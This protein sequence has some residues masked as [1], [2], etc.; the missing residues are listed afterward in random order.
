MEHD[1][2]E[3]EEFSR[4]T[5]SDHDRRDDPD[6][7]E[8]TASSI[9]IHDIPPGRSEKETVI[10]QG[11]DKR[12][13]SEPDFQS[14]IHKIHDHRLGS[15]SSRWT[16]Q[17]GL[18][19]LPSINAP[20]HNP[21]SSEQQRSGKSDRV[22][23]SNG[24][25]L[26]S[27]DSI[28]SLCIIDR[29]GFG[30][31]LLVHVGIKGVESPCV[32]KK[33]IHVGSLD[34]VRK[35]RKEFKIQ[36]KLYKCCKNRIPYPIFILDLLNKEYK[37]NFGFVME[38]C[39][40]GNVKE[41]A[42]SWCRLKDISSS[43]GLQR[44]GIGEK[45]EEKD[46]EGSSGEYSEDSMSD[47]DSFSHHFDPMTLDPLKVSALCVEIIECLDDVFKANPW[48]IHRDIKPENFLIKVDSKNNECSVVL[49]DH[50]LAQIKRSV[51]ESSQSSLEN[52]SSDSSSSSTSQKSSKSSTGHILC[53]TYAY[54]SFEALQGMHSQKS[55]AYSLGITI[56]ALFQCC[57]P[58][59]NMRYLLNAISSTEFVG[60]L[61]ELLSKGI[62]PKLSS[63]PL[64]ASILSINSKEFE[65]V[66]SCLNEVFEGLT[67]LEVG[68]RMSVHEACEKVQSIKPLLPKIGE[69]WECPSIEDIVEAHL[70]KHK[71]NSGCIVEA[72]S[73]ESGF[74]GQSSSQGQ[75][76][77]PYQIPKEHGKFTS[78]ATFKSEEDL[79]KKDKKKDEN[80]PQSPQIMKPY[81]IPDFQALVRDIQLTSSQASVRS[82]FK[83]SSPRLMNNFEDWNQKQFFSN[84]IGD[85]SSS[86]AS[87]R[88]LFTLCFEC[89]SLFVQHECASSSSGF[90]DDDSD[91]SILTL[92]ESSLMELIGTFLTPMIRVEAELS[93]MDTA[94][95][96]GEKCVMSAITKSLVRIVSIAEQKVKSFQTKLSPQISSV[97]LRI[98]KSLD[99][100]VDEIK[101]CPD[102]ESKFKLYH[103]HRDDILSVFFAFQSKREIEKHKREIVLCVHCLSWFVRHV[104]SGNN[105]FLPIPDL[106][107]LI[108]TFIGHL[109]R[110]EE[111]LEGD[112][113]EEY[114]RIC[115]S[116][117]FKVK[118]ERDHFLPKISP[119]LQSILER[120]SKE[121]LG[122][123]ISRYLLTT[124]RNISISP[125]SSIKSSIITLINPYIR[126]WLRIY[127]DS[128]CYGRWMYILSKITLSSD[129]ESPNKSLCSEAWP[130]FR[131]VLDVVKREFVGDKI[132]GDRYEYVL[133]F[134][135]NLCC[136]PSHA[137]E[138]YDNVKDL[139]DGWLVVI[140]KKEH[141]SGIN[142]WSR[143]ISMFST[144][145]HLVPR[146]SPK[147]D[148]DIDWCKN[149]G[150]RRG[151]YI[152][153]LENCNLIFRLDK[154]VKA[155]KRCTDI[156]SL[157]KLF[158][159]R[160]NEI[161]SVFLAYQS[162]SKIRR[163]K[164]EIVLCVHCLSWFVCHVISGNNIFL[165]IPDLND[166]IDTFIGHLSRCE[167]VLE[168]D[169]DEEYCRICV[170]YTHKV[171]DKRDHFL[172]KISPTLQSILERGSKEKLGGNVAI[173]LL[174]TLRNI[175][176]SPSSSIKSS[177]ITLI[178]SYI[179]DWLRIYNDSEC[180]G[181]W[182]Y[183][184]S[185]ITLS[186]DDESPN[187]SLCSEAWPLFRPVLDVVKREF[188]GDKIVE[189]D[190]Y[191]VLFFFSNLCC[192]PSHVHEIYDNIIDLLDGWYEAVKKKKHEWGIRY[193]S[194]LISMLSA[195]PSL[196]SL[197]SPKYD[198]HMEWCK[199]NGGWKSDYS[200][201]CN[202]C[203]S[204]P[205]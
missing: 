2:E 6:D 193:W 107:D 24:I 43:K 178:K 130:L 172:P 105:I 82:L 121:K 23:K 61:L 141:K 65:P 95:G 98:M 192:D 135:S 173:N 90:G 44:S 81:S 66:Y 120:G 177:I 58:F 167:E 190:Y 157:S 138:V 13:Y 38:F 7:S 77:A 118:D 70:V 76:V 188:V 50:G 11:M 52:I 162:K 51:I 123:N 200:K 133:L 40:G 117:T 59:Y 191:D 18:P 30:E 92:D 134:F 143:L 119:T 97:W 139:L 148:L 163:H 3:K 35:C 106:N 4:S 86:L 84:P 185:K 203:T 94:E 108:D 16:D 189:K 159:E 124:L 1:K 57:N 103:E 28:T 14:H 136:D 195:S 145:P 204:F 5:Q 12:R 176:I 48:F 199:D 169:V 149:N 201:Y 29:G 174:M 21:S 79:R 137:L 73:Y 100:L 74:D 96:S 99:A 69:G 125:S 34:L 46:S 22:S 129:D 54:D 197:L 17:Y 31:L 156:E 142:L 110:C 63:S 202:N 166:L 115:V 196:V 104:I 152:R 198:T 109:S 170:N 146:I 102:S 10:A 56:L 8:Y 153:Y 111:V 89:L 27:A 32:L 194:K 122:E 101:K 147:Y 155:I 175:S 205:K 64:F 85:S 179:R 116:Y 158:V 9:S 75:S 180:Y 150:G 72:A 19:G 128:E 15:S 181:R 47:L 67:T 154:L 160:R 36:R 140:K 39:A 151:D 53:G 26:S 114:C 68:K 93:K 60:K 112:V 171:K 165:P 42:R 33:M 182:M 41:F 164:R 83:S 87:D 132:V 20:L 71:G 88:A 45:E 187:K 49:S 80:P 126:D 62:G 37:G 78:S 144:I 161:L 131:P 91:R 186:S 127:N 168:G 55:D 25:T 113:D 183:I 184:L